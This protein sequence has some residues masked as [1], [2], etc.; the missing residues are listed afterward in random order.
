MSV[1]GNNILIGLPQ[2]VRFLHI[3]QLEEFVAGRT[4]LQEVLNADLERTKIIEEAAGM[5]LIFI[6]N[7]CR[8]I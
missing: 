1:L 5:S 4:I 8:L 2:N 3:T 7:S 6:G